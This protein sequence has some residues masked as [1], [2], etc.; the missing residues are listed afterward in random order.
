VTLVKI[1][2]LNKIGE[3]GLRHMGLE[4]DKEGLG[5]GVETKK[6]PDQ[7]AQAG[8]GESVEEEGMFL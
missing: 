7:G 6:E 2:L 5:G 8:T 3:G 4:V 1:A